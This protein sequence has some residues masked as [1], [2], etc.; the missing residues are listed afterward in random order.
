MPTGSPRQVLGPTKALTHRDKVAITGLAEEIRSR[1]LFPQINDMSLFL[2]SI[3]E[4][5]VVEGTRSKRR[6]RGQPNVRQAAE[7]RAKVLKETP[8]HM[9]SSNI[10]PGGLVE[11]ELDSDT[12]SSVST[13]TGELGGPKVTPR[14]ADEL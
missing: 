8:L 4:A 9:Q 10:T 12:A 1:R 7:E 14:S 13:V 2:D 6:T 11:L 3:D 5:F